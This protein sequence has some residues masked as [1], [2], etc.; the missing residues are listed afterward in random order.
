MSLLESEASY[1]RC[2]FQINIS[3]VNWMICHGCRL[4]LVSQESVECKWPKTKHRPVTLVGS[5]GALQMLL[6]YLLISHF[7]WC[8][9]YL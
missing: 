8:I 9:C 3:A 6:T 7:C 5:Y 4:R 2:I 1:L